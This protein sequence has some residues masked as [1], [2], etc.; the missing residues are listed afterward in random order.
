MM[1]G[2][3]YFVHDVSSSLEKLFRAIKY[4]FVAYS[5]PQKGYKCYSPTNK[6]YHRSV[7]VAFIE[8]T[9]F[10]LVLHGNS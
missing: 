8:D 2:C 4:A 6:R 5:H 9:P 1:F 3:T 10:F 7:D